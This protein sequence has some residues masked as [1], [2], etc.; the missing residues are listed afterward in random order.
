M[1]KLTAAARNSIPSR[2]FALPHERKYPVENKSHARNAKSRAKQQF[3]IGKL[4]KAE[5]EK[6][7]AA[8]DKKLG[9]KDDA[10]NS[11]KA[12]KAPGYADGGA[13]NPEGSYAD[14]GVV[15]RRPR[16]E[17]QTDGYANGG[18]VKMAPMFPMRKQGAVSQD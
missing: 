16:D 3:D 11:G 12:K 1:A 4:S 18:L 8:A 9:D 6:I 7:D 15:E 2:G 5:L 10:P 13:V 17:P 14:G